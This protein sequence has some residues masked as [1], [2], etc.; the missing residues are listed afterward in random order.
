M[1]EIEAKN[2]KNQVRELLYDYPDVFTSELKGLPPKRGIYDHA[3]NLE[4]DAKPVSLPSF[5]YTPEDY[6]EVFQA[7][8]ICNDLMLYPI[9]Q[10]WSP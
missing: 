6:Q 2:M 8:M 3:I 9:K 1:E 5:R 4:K 7:L 10:I